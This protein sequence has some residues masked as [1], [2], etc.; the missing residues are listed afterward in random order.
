MRERDVTV[1][2]VTSPARCQHLSS[3]GNEVKVGVQLTAELDE[4]D[5]EVVTGWQWASGASTGPWTNI[6]GA[7]DATYTPVDGDVGNFLRITVAYTMP[8]SGPDSLSRVTAS[9]VEAATV[10]V[11]GTAGSVSLSPSADW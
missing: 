9:A 7:T 5:E 1:T 2:N 10:T 11:P 6:S 4:Q 8:R 3:P